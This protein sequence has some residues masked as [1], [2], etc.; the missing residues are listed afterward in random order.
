MIS[1]IDILLQ[2]TILAMDC[3]TF[4]I[5]NDFSKVILL[6]TTFFE[7]IF[8]DIKSWKMDVFSNSVMVCRLQFCKQVLP[9]YWTNINIHIWISSINNVIP[10]TMITASFMFTQ[11]SGVIKNKQTNKEIKKQRNKQKIKTKT[12][13][14]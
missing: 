9:M 7:K 10:I 5:S 2:T 6:Q 14:L 12:Y 4:C 3:W 1:P 13:S 11:L 8:N